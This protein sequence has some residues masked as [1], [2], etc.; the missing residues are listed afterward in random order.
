MRAA[1]ILTALV[2]AAA[3]APSLAATP[4]SS[5]GSST[6]GHPAQTHQAKCDEQRKACYAAKVQI[7]QYGSRYVPPEA[8]TECEAAYRMCVKGG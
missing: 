6:S 8:V 4:G 5:T 1:R 7:G 2:L 3:A